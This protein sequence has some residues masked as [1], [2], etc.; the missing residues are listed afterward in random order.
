RAVTGAVA[1]R[2]PL[3]EM[4]RANLSADEDQAAWQALGR[5]AHSGVLCVQVPH[6]SARAPGAVQRLARM[7]SELPSTAAAVWAAS[8]RLCEQLTAAGLDSSRVSWLP[9]CVPTGPA[10][11]GGE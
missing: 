11:P 10:G 1:A 8:P 5:P 9:P 3:F 2:E 7:P 6:G 4:A